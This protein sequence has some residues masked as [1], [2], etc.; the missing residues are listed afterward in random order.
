MKGLD[1]GFA[2]EVTQL[3][4]YLHEHPEI[5]WQEFETTQFVKRLLEKKGC[6]IRTF[7]DCPGVIGEIGEGSPVIALRADMDALWQ[8]V[9]GKFQ[10]NHSCGHDAHMTMVLGVLLALKKRAVIRQGTVRFIFQPAEEKGT[11]ALKMVEKGVVDDVDYLYGVHLRPFQEVENGKASPAIVHGAARLIQGEIIGEDAHG[12]RPHLGKSA[13]EVGAALVN[14]INEI[15]LDPMI[16]YSIKLTKLTAG[17]KNAN[18]IPGYGEFSVDLRAQ[19]NAAME[20]L[21]QRLHQII[22]QLSQQFG[23]DIRFLNMTHVAGAIVNK[24]AQEVMTESICKALGVENLE[25][26]VVTTGGDDFHFY[27]LKRPHI[28]ATMLGLGCGLT[29]GL[30]HPDMT[31]DRKA[32]FS[33][34]EILT[35]TVLITLEKYGGSVD[36]E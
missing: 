13:I 7:E 6:R 35:E 28:K 26:P 24:E 22:Q 23:V 3:F 19:T 20:A 36:Y 32:L 9:K 16:P 2:E 21:Y 17:G 33:G 31:F 8:Q 34:I 15:H 1:G 29:P 27:A 25:A 12:A 11:G 4:T 30:H 14:F 10:A 18:I 5:S